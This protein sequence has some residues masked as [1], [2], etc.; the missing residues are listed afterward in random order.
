ML[1]IVAVVAA[2]LF[3]PTSNAG[4][5]FGYGRGFPRMSQQQIKFMQDQM[6]AAQEQEKAKQDAFMKRFDTNKN[7]KIDGK[8][9]GPAQKYLRQ[10]ELGKD[11]DKAMK[12][13]GRTS[14]S[15][16]SKRAK[17]AISE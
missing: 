10:L 2:D 7:G 6:K 4:A 9:K 17:P 14:G 8:E 3:V 15:S 1:T 5:Q 11:P 12:S 13:L 16:K